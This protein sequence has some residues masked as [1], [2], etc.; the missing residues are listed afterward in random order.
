LKLLPF[1]I[2]A[3]PGPLLS[4]GTV[5][6]RMGD[7]EQIIDN[8]AA[9]QVLLD[10]PLERG[11]I[12]AAIPGAFRIDD[13]DRPAFADSEAIRFGPQ[14]SALFRKTEL[15][16]TPLEKLPC[17]KALLFLATFWRRLVAAEK[18][19][20]PRHRHTNAVGNLFLSGHRSQKALSSRRFPSMGG[21]AQTNPYY[22]GYRGLRAALAP[23]WHAGGLETWLHRGIIEETPCEVTCQSESLNP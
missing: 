14:D 18:D 16:Q 23:V 5:F 20:T 1:Q 4:A 6:Q 15:L 12:A 19:V 11:R 9:H 13:G 21:R 7:N 22:R 3:G 10:N 2:R 17:G 8:A